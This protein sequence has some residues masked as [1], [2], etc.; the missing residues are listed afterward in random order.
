MSIPRKVKAGD[1]ITADYINSIVDSIKE[2][3]INAFVGGS[4]KRG[5]DGTTLTISPKKSQPVG[6]EI[7]YP[8]EFYSGGTVSEPWFGLRAGTING[9][10][11]VNWSATFSLPQATTAG[12]TKYINLNCDTDGKQVTQVTIALEDSP[13]TPPPY[14]PSLAPVTFSINAY[15]VIN[16]TAYRTIGPS[17]IVAMTFETIREEKATTLSFGEVPFTIYYTW[18]FAS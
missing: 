13:P 14:A 7:T 1:S 17:S 15:A 12:Y 3:Q 8:F 16:G 10:F 11:P 5:T 9:T 2:C 4:F 6:V 18:V